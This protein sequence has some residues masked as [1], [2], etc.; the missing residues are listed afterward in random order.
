[1]IPAMVMSESVIPSFS[2]EELIMGEKQAEV[3][4]ALTTSGLLKVR[5]PTSHR[6]E[7]MEG[8]CRCVER[9]DM[10][11]FEQIRL[12][13]GK[14]DRISIGASTVGTTPLPVPN[15]EELCGV[16][17]MEA[18]ENL[19]DDVA[20]ASDAF[21][22]AFD[23]LVGNQNALLQDSN[24]KSYFSLEQIRQSANHLEHF[25]VYQKDENSDVRSDHMMDDSHALEW[26][27]DAGLFLSFVPA[28]DCKS[29]TSSEGTFL[30]KDGQN[31]IS[32]SFRDDEI[33]L[34]MGAG[35]ENWLSSS[36]DLKATH[37]AVRLTEGS[38]RSWYGMSKLLGSVLL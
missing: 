11:T 9:S 7:A 19:R 10:D 37:H 15:L 30:F 38:I 12:N 22:T 29:G 6:E 16:D 27:T 2:I 20:A 32:P 17:T 23:K 31:I 36:I 1:M 34:M 24:G 25:H 21:V 18:I 5:L 14:T 28:W 8:L 4:R 13:D 26:H 33:V 35:A 3:L